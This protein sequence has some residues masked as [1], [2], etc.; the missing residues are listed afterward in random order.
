MYE[1]ERYVRSFHKHT[2]SHYTSTQYQLSV[3]A[4]ERRLPLLR[5]K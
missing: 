1:K 4:L 3:L 5:R 2:K